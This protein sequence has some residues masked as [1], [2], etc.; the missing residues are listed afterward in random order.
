MILKLPGRLSVSSSEAGTGAGGDSGVEGLSGRGGQWKKVKLTSPK[1]C[2]WP[3][4][5]KL[6]NGGALVLRGGGGGGGQLGAHC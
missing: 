3:M 2:D 4:L 5:N 1:L 6:K